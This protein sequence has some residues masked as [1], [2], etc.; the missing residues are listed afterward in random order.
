LAASGNNKRTALLLLTK[1]PSHRYLELPHINAR[2]FFF[3]ADFATLFADFVRQSIG[4][5]R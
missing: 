4:P 2:F 1:E 5:E 3:I